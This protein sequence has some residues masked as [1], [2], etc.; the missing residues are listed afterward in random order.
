MRR[1][2]WR[3]A[4]DAV[5]SSI[6][7][8]LA[9]LVIL[10]LLTMVTTGWAPEWTKAKESEHMRMVESQFSNLKA[11][12]DQL[13][14]SANTDTVVSTPLTLGSE[15]VPLF[16]SDATGT[17]SLLS[18]NDNSFNTFSV[19]NESGLFERV[20]YGSILFRSANTEYLDQTFIYESGSLIIKQDDGQVV[21]TGPGLI[22]QNLTQ[23]ISVSATLISVYSDGSSYSGVGT[24]GINARLVQEKITTVRTW[25]VTDTVHINVSTS[26]Y[27]AWYEYF[28]RIVPNSEVGAGDYDLSVDQST[29]TVHLTL[30][31][32][33]R[34]TTDYVIIGA[35]L[36][37][38]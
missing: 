33:Y 3:R 26:V 18:T 35:S 7:T 11:L 16:S 22:I 4:E 19:E 20:A 15:G 14:L 23:G 36:D 1:G 27:Q 37:L 2:T 12:M 5:A 9:I 21:T 10:A 24:V 31:N 28:Q 38:S 17:V 34:L 6:G 25:S 32:V 29:S 30:R 13:S 8:M